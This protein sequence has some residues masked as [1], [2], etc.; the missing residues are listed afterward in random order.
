MLHTDRDENVFDGACP[1]ILNGIP[2]LAER[3]DLN[4]RS[5]WSISRQFLMN[6]VGRRMISTQNGRSRGRA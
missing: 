1:I 5:L 3:P 6:V 2:A 4:D